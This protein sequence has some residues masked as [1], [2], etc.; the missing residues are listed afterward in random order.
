M[1]WGNGAISETANPGNTITLTCG[2]CH[3]PHGN[4][5]Y[6]IL[7][8]AP[9]EALNYI[10]GLY[11]TK[12]GETKEEETARKAA[13]AASK[14]SHEVTIPDATTKV[15]TTENYGKMADPNQPA[16]IENISKWC[17]TCH[18]RYLAPSGS[19]GQ[20]AGVGNSGDAMFAYRH[21]TEYLTHRPQCITCHVAHGSDAAMNG[22]AAEVNY[23]GESLLAPGSADSRLLRI[24]NRGVCQA[25]HHK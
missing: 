16:F 9:T 20:T 25:C 23:P 8:P 14:A 18:T 10:K 7:R 24:E 12:P 21:T 4:G 6:R 17:S 2:S 13:E 15:Y 11:P 1:A 5:N 3:D 22:K 19:A